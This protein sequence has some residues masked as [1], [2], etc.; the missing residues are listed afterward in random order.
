MLSVLALIEGLLD[1]GLT[2]EELAVSLGVD[3]TAIER[4]QSGR[5]KPRPFTEGALRRLHSKVSSGGIFATRLNGEA[6]LKD[7]LHC[8]LQELREVLHRSGRLSSRNEALDELS[9]LLFAH[10]MS[11]EH[12]AGGIRYDELTRNYSS[13]PAEALN[14]FVKEMFE[15]HLPTSLSLEMGPND[16]QLRLKP[17]EEHFAREVIQVFEHLAPVDSY[18]HA[19]GLAG[20]DLLND[21]FGQ[22]LADSFVDEKELG[23]YLTPTEVVQF[24]VRWW[25]TTLSEEELEAWCHPQ[26]CVDK[27]FVLDPSCGVGSFLVEVLRQ[28]HGD[29][30]RRHGPEG[31]ATWV[32]NMTARVLIGVDKSERMVRMALTNLAM[33]GFPAAN[34]HLANALLRSGHDAELT[35][36]LKGK[37]QLILT[38]P[39]FGAEFSEG[40]KHYKIAIQWTAKRPNKVDSE[41]LF[42]ERYTEWLAPAG[43]LFVI[44]PDSI[45]TNKGLFHDLRRG[46]AP[47]VEVR[48]VISLPSITF[49]LAG[50]TTKTSIL[51]LQRRI[52]E[53]YD[54]V[55]TFFA[56]C[57]D[58]GYDVV[59]RDSQRMKVKTEQGDLPTILRDL[60][61]LS[62]D[63]AVGRYVTG[64]TESFR[65]DA[66]YHATLPPEIEVRIRNPQQ[67]DVYVRDIA[68]MANDRRDP[69]QFA[70][71]TFVYIEIS[72][73]DS[74]TLTVNPKRILCTE[75]PS[76]ARVLVRG[77]DVLVSTVRAGNKTIAVVPFDLDGAICSTG[78]AV[79]RPFG[80]D[81]YALARLLQTDFVTLQLLR[82]NVGIAYPAI[83]PECLLDVILPVNREDLVVLS[84]AAKEVADAY[85]RARA[86]RFEFEQIIKR[87]FSS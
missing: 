52:S 54:P 85:E 60:E 47:L 71:E 31:L 20:C 55:R 32:K 49:G 30:E 70:S 3:C 79:L 33:F 26:R 50:T 73:V 15:N 12:G 81:P 19:W 59:T 65:W 2:K 82:N 62:N 7:A 39:P 22:F 84:E 58:I 69:R 57:R 75:A 29:V 45:L 67:T 56:I 64:V 66:T 42:M 63:M 35:N 4:W 21:I 6:L 43:K 23:Q 78:F 17:Q 16:F 9:K 1:F 48:G 72:D 83:E 34:L 86:K 5:S 10:I 14:L 44:V 27:A 36:S 13:N 41:L 80:I 74:A 77:G 46:L 68:S 38:N 25:L 40:L 87:V 18:V 51:Y 28:L 61:Q 24:M 53:Q 76:R 8:T 37:V 11:I